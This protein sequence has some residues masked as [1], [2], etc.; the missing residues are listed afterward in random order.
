VGH[1]SSPPIASF[2]LRCPRGGDSGYPQILRIPRLRPPDRRRLPKSNWLNGPPFA[3]L[4]TEDS[5]EFVFPGDAFRPPSGFTPRFL[6][7]ATRSWFFHS[8][9]RRISS[10]SPARDFHDFRLFGCP[11]ED[12]TPFSSRLKALVWSTPQPSLQPFS[13]CLNAKDVLVV[14]A[15]ARA[16]PFA[17]SVSRTQLRFPSVDAAPSFPAVF[18]NGSLRSSIVVPVKFSL[19]L[20]KLFFRQHPPRLAGIHLSVCHRTCYLL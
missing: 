16:P 3:F 17:R 20:L 13:P 19:P 1:A 7:G 9:L 11:R 5:N 12:S 14:L 10:C 4:P 2:P 18:Q 15:Y 6:T 8:F